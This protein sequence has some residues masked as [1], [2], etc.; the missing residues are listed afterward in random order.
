M[1]SQLALPTHHL[2]ALHCAGKRGVRKGDKAGNWEQG[3]EHVALFSSL[4]SRF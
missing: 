3:C 4:E 2:Q 1:C